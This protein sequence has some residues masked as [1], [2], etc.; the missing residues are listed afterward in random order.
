MALGPNYS[1][2]LIHWLNRLHRFCREHCSLV[3]S[4]EFHVAA[5][6]SLYPRSRRAFLRDDVPA[7][8]QIHASLGQCRGGGGGV[9]TAG[10]AIGPVL[11]QRLPQPRMVGLR[12]PR[13]LGPPTLQIDCNE[14]PANY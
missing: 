14:P 6:S 12:S 10:A 2:S 9:A 13:S 3:R 5:T 8:A 4:G 7:L 11:R 1:K